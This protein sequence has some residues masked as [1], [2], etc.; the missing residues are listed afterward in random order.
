[1]NLELTRYFVKVV[2]NG[3]FTRAAE[4]LKLPKSTVS[5]AIARLERE[6]GT[7]LLLRTTRSLT[8]TAAGRAFYDASLAA[9]QT[10]EDAQKSLHGQDSILTGLL[11]IT[12]PEDLG[13]HVVAP[14]IASLAKKHAGL[15]FELQYTNEVIDLVKDGYDLAVRIGRVNESSFKVKR[16]GD[17]VLIAVATPGYLKAGEK[18]RVPKDLSTHQCLSYSR[19]AFNTRW[20]LRSKKE[21][22]AVQINARIASNQMTSLHKM[23]LAGSGIAFLPAW[24]CAADVASGRL[25]RVLPEWSAPGLPVSIITPLAPSSSAR[26]KIT[27]EILAE[28]IAKALNPN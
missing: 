28:T 21:T 16:A 18:I 12:A 10:L 7:K 15:N 2:Q 19:Q 17:V 27:T 23:A 9:V 14:A 8:L 24:M 25:L 5:K 6:T 11:R 20:T 26:L 22:Q 4:L 1:M 13:S 3:S